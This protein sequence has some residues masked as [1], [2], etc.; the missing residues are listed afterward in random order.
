MYS[1]DV[2]N[3]WRC[4]KYDQMFLI[5][6]ENYKFYLIPL[7]QPHIPSIF[8]PEQSVISKGFPSGNLFT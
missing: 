1:N 5:F 2:I 8:T 7:P 6:T 3:Y 4:L